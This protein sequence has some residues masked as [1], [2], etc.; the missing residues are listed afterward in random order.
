[1]KNGVVVGRF[2]VPSLHGGHKVLIN[3]ALHECENVLIVIGQAPT[4]K[5]KKNPL[6]VEDVV[7]MVKEFTDDYERGVMFACISDM[8]N[9]FAWSAELDR[10]IAGFG[11]STKDTALYGSRDS[12]IEHY[13]GAYMQRRVKATS[14]GSGTVS[15]FLCGQYDRKRDFRRGLITAQQERLP[16]IYPV[17][18]VAV[19]KFGMVL[20][21]RKKHDPIGQYRFFGGFVDSADQSLEGAAIRE[22][23]EESGVDVKIRSYI[24]S[25]QVNDWR[26]R[27][28][29]DVI[30]SSFYVA[31]WVSGE[32]VA[33]DDISEVFLLHPC[34]LPDKIVGEHKELAFKFAD[35]YIKEI[36]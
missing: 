10:I 33:G 24:T 1:M 3:N 18:D 6:G 9:D 2:Q 14:A 4:L 34:E 13:H 28:T 19:I 7:A 5:T 11:F 22:V 23:R 30:M 12:F 32:H 27:G 16:I 8:P 15:R 26:Y 31:D 25:S 20:V 35:W 29:E 17:V 36:R 21:G